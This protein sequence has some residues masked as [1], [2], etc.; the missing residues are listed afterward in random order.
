MFYDVF[1]WVSSVSRYLGVLIMI[2]LSFFRIAVEMKCRVEIRYFWT[3]STMLVGFDIKC[4]CIILF[5][6]REKY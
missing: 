5:N 2:Y 3:G 6:E 1:V 4:Y